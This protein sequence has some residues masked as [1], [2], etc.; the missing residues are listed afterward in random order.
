MSYTDVKFTLPELYNPENDVVF[1][2][3]FIAWA[4]T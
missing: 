4:C 3:E 1:G 2:K